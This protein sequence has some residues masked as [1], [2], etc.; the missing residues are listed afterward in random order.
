LFRAVKRIDL[1]AEF[2]KRPM[3]RCPQGAGLP[4]GQQHLPVIRTI[5]GEDFYTI[6][7]E[8]HKKYMM[9]CLDLKH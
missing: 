1:E 6:V 7:I 2:P 5:Y 4:P 8:S 9:H 3:P